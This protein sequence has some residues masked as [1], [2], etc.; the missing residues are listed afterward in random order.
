[1]SERLDNRPETELDSILDS[2]PLRPEAPVAIVA[3][4]KEPPV[5]SPQEEKRRKVE[6][7]L[8]KLAPLRDNKLG[9]IV[10]V[11]MSAVAVASGFMATESPP[12]PPPPIIPY[13]FPT[14][15]SPAPLGGIDAAGAA[16]TGPFVTAPSK[17]G[18]SWPE[19]VQRVPVAAYL[20]GSEIVTTGGR[21]IRVGE[22]F[23]LRYAGGVR[24]AKLIA[25]DEAGW[26]IGD[27]LGENVVDVPAPTGIFDV[28]VPTDEAKAVRIE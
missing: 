4:E 13:S 25:V 17:E 23:P 8:T 9:P 15:V 11:L 10:L 5:A 1:M 26:S 7:D 12:T 21:V 16:S 22:S 28:V 20:P 19:L 27:A 18:V 2:L 6:I 24:Q 3:D 14:P